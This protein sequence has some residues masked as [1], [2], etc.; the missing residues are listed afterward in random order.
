MAYDETGAPVGEGFKKVSYYDGY[1]ISR[2]TDQQIFDIVGKLDKKLK[3]LGEMDQDS[4]AVKH[5]I[6]KL[7]EDREAL[8]AAV[9]G[10][11]PDA[12]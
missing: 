9:D 5:H 7:T 11:Y 12:E 1:D 8:M 2:M 3:E 6:A 10:R 4:K